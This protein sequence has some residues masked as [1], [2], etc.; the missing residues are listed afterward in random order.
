MVNTRGSRE[1]MEGWQ[2]HHLIPQQCTR[3]A[4]T[5]SFFSAMHDVGFRLNDFRTNGILLPSTHAQAA[6][7][8][9]P[10]HSGPHPEYNLKIIDAV[11]FIARR[12]NFASDRR[13]AHAALSH[14]RLIQ[15]RLRISMY[16][17][18]PT[19]IDSIETPTIL[20]RSRVIDRAIDTLLAR[21]NNCVVAAGD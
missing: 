16:Q 13:E 6:L 11:G 7:A 21:V 18:R 14:V 9:L 4:R 15:A 3:D 19:P 10:V 17:D 1:Y 5:R 2:R 8:R 20:K 12:F